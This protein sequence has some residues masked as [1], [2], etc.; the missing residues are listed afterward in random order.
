MPDDGAEPSAS[1]SV[2]LFVER[3]RAVVPDFAPDASAMSDIAAIVRTLDG[4]PLAIELAA[5]RTKL[6]SVAAVRAHLDEAL[7]LLGGGDAADTRHHTMR[8][9]LAWSYDPLVEADQRLLRRLSVFAGGFTLDAAARV[10]ANASDALD[11]LDPVGRLAEASLLLVTRRGDEEPRYHLPE[12]LRQFLAELPAGDG[13]V[14]QVRERH[15]RYFVELA[16]RETSALHRRDMAFAMAR[17]DR[18]AANCGAA[19]RWCLRGPDAR[20]ALE[21]AHALVPYW[22]DRGLLAHARARMQEVLAHPAADRDAHARIEALLDAATLDLDCEQ[23]SEAAARAGDAQSAAQA[24]DAQGLRCRA[25]ALRAHASVALGAQWDADIAEAVALA[26]ALPDRALLRATLDDA[27][28]IFAAVERWEEATAAVDESLAIARTSD[29]APAL[30]TALRDAAQ[31]AAAR[32]DAAR[33]R[34]LLREAVD[35]ALASHAQIDGEHDLETASALAAACKDWTLAARFLGAADAARD[36][37]TQ[38]PAHPRT[39]PQPIRDAQGA[40]AFEVRVRGRGADRAPAGPDGGARLARGRIL[41]TMLLAYSPCY[42][43]HARPRRTQRDERTPPWTDWD[44][45]RS[46]RSSA[47]ARWPA[48][49]RPTTR[50]STASSRSSC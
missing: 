22:R 12:T 19:H 38:M 31:V 7:K 43:A 11:V 30:H 1:D 20:P 42:Q 5:A 49:T 4:I 32:G 29:D 17:L 15:A 24:I 28:E 34:P 25:L 37:M 9:S 27:G 3:A 16:R 39:G 13:D 41:V 45:T 14:E 10:A 50:T 18:E 44:A 8:A 26:R 23:W 6:L 46:A 40:V 36:A 48:C 21:L 2:R 47:K 33:A 35:I